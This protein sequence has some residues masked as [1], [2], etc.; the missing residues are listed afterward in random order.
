MGLYFCN[1]VFLVLLSLYET[2]CR[3]LRSV[4]LDLR[5]Q[6]EFLFTSH[7]FK[8]C[9]RTQL[10]FHWIESMG[11]FSALT[12]ITSNYVTKQLKCDWLEL[13]DVKV[14]LQRSVSETCI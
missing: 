6:L 1:L 3:S 12:V 5:P 2:Y 13:C 8:I 4:A 14:L 11:M 9:T 10:H 7:V